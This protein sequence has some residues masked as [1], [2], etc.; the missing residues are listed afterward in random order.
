MITSG[1]RRAGGLEHKGRT[2]DTWVRACIRFGLDS[3][4]RKWSSGSFSGP[5]SSKLPA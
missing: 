4:W 1:Q 3:G 5:Q 2:P